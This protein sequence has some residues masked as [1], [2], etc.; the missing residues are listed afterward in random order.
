MNFH[1]ELILLLKARYPI[2]YISTFEEDRLEYTIRN[3]AKGISTRNIYVWDFIDGYKDNP[4]NISQTNG[5]RN[6]LQ[7]L[8]FIE[9][10]N[11]NAQTIFVL[12]DFRRFLTDITISRKLRN[13]IRILKTESKTIIIIDSIIEIPNE[14]RDFITVLKFNLPNFKEIN[15]ELLRLIN[16]LD[17]KE[18]IKKSLLEK[19]TLSCQGL[20]LERIRRV[21]GKIL[22][23]NKSFDKRA[24]SF[25]LEEKKQIINQTNILEFWTAYETLE[26]VGGLYE[27]KKWLKRRSNSFSEKAYNY[28]LPVPRGVLLIGVQGSGKSLIAKALANDWKLPLLRLDVGRLFGGIVG[29]SEARIRDMIEISEALAPCILWID[30]IDKAFN[31]SGQVSDSGTTKRVLATFI[32]WLAEKTEPVFIVATANNIDALPIEI[33]R[34][35]RFDEIFFIGLP[36]KNERKMI[37]QVHLA[38]VR[39]ETWIYY[40]IEKLSLVTN[41]F[42][43]AEIQQSII[44]AMHMAFNEK[45]EF[46]TEDIIICC[47]QIIPLAD[48]NPERIDIIQDLAYSGRIRLA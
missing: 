42:S 30:E 27:L 46:K 44:E 48:T 12:K 15:N 37:F 32:T 24:I 16:K 13:L 25:I 38:K 7:A 8:E 34:K 9:K 21:L 6:P 43:G 26:E 31:D 3:C 41:N 29:E 19:I 2:I 40:D 5:K 35:G 17:I 11:S 14:L 36:N 39:P 45:R 22:I 20:S 23:L 47:K 28:G 33:L 10:V 18:P 4:T 1:Q